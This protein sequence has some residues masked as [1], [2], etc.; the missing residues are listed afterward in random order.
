LAHGSASSCPPLQAIRARLNLVHWH[1]TRR[2]LQQT[3][4]HRTSDY[5]CCWPRTHAT[6]LAAPRQSTRGDTK[7]TRSG[8]AASRRR[9][10]AAIRDLRHVKCGSTAWVGDMFH[11]TLSLGLTFPYHISLRRPIDPRQKPVPT[12]VTAATYHSLSSL[13]GCFRQSLA[14]VGLRCPVLRFAKDSRP[15]ALLAHVRRPS[16][17]A[18]HRC[19]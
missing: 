15:M 16:P 11:A 1:A 5:I 6:S 4:P 10:L 2:A 8:A 14:S 18:S 3:H 9:V 13:H 17:A 19:H 12:E 7:G